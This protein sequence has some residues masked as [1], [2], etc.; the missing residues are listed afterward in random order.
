MRVL[1]MSSCLVWWSLGG[2]GAAAGDPFS[3]DAQGKCDPFVPLVRNGQL[4]PCRPQPSRPTLTLQG[5][6]WDPSGESIA[7]I[8]DREVKVGDSID[9]Y[10]VAEIRHDA[11]VLVQE[12]TVLAL[13]ISLEDRANGAIR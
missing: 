11:V 8:D 10:Q 1:V 13:T 2:V 9:D 3:Y 12:G 4:V 5:I 7:L 6:V